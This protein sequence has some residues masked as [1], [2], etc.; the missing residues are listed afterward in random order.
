LIPITYIRSSSYSAFS[1]C[2]QKFLLHY[3]LGLEDYS[4]KKAIVGNIVHKALELIAHKKLCI[5]NCEVS[6]LEKELDKTYNIDQIT[7]EFSIKE[8][9]DYYTAKES[10]INETKNPWCALDLKH[11]HKHLK[12]TLEFNDSMFSPLNRNVLAPEQY[13][14][15]EINEPWARYDYEVNGQ[16]ISGTLACRGTVDLVT[17]LTPDTIELL[18]WKTGQAKDWNTGKRKTYKTLESDF[19]LRLYHLA[20][21]LLYPNIEHIIITIFFIKDG[22][23]TSICFS[24]SDTKKT[25]DMIRERFEE[26][27]ACQRPKIITKGADLWKCK[28][29][30]RFY[31]EKQPGTDKSI[32]RFFKDEIVKLGISKVIDKYCDVAKVTQYQ[33]GGGKSAETTRDTV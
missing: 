21:T 9:W 18:D 2:Q 20:L 30:C 7:S 1:W 16:K 15:F 28:H 31:N 4:N 23:P 19:Q 6:F 26:I 5:Q 27:R 22:G 29:L 8:A 25:Y 13:F 10:R 32:C 12:D 3:G 14:D 24:K 11:C 17:L 33:D